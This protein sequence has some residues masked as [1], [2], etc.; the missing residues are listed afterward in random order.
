MATKQNKHTKELHKK[1]PKN[2]RMKQSNVS[3][4]TPKNNVQFNVRTFNIKNLH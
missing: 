1:T 2:P 3:S 4:I